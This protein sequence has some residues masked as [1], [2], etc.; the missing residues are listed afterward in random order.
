MPLCPDW[1][2]WRESGDLDVSICALVLECKYLEELRQYLCFCTS[3]CVS[4]CTFVLANLCAL[5]EVIDLIT[6]FR[7]LRAH[8]PF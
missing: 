3:S 4:I 8:A 5:K 1:W 7:I 6:K 2:G